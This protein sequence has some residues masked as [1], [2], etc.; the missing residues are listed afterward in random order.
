VSR[1]EAQI[2]QQSNACSDSCKLPQVDENKF[3]KILSTSWITNLLIMMTSSFTQSIFSHILL[4]DGHLKHLKAF[5]EQA[6][7]TANF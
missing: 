5:G 7:G 3:P 1:Y 4:A 6:R 2:W